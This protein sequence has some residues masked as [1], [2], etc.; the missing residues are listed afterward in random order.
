MEKNIQERRRF[1]RINFDANCILRTSDK[2]WEIKLIDICF[3]GALAESNTELPL[4]IGDQAELIIVLDGNEVIIEMPAIINHRRDKYL[5][6]K[7]QT[8]KLSSISHL[9]RL[10]ELNLGD[11]TLLERELDHLYST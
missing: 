2:E 1:T 4:S 11:P 6:F 10:V 5:G 9:R 3:K 8:M 7:A